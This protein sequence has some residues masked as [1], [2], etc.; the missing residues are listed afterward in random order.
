MLELGPGSDL[1][2]GALILHR[3]AASYLAVDAFDNR[4]QASPELYRALSQS[5]GSEIA[6][7]RL[8]YRGERR[9]AVLIDNR[10]D[11][12]RAWEQKGGTGYWFRNDEQFV[13]D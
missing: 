9:D 8:G 4:D 6:L 11:L 3:G 5:L 7:D 2:T 10:L 12:V 1:A 13:R